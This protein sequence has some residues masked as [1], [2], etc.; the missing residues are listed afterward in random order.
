M[1]RLMI[2]LVLVCSLALPLSPAL[3]VSLSL[4]PSHQ[5]IQL[6]DIAYVDLV[7]SDLGTTI[8]GAFDVDIT[9]D[10]FILDPVVVAF[11]TSLGDIGSGE[12]I[13]GASLISPDTV[14]VFEVSLL[15][16]FELAPLQAVPSFALA[17]LG[18]EGIAFGSSDLDFGDVILSDDFGFEITEVTT[19]GARVDVVPEPTTILLLGVGLAGF[20][21]FR[22]KSRK[23]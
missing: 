12:A 18:F 14:N 17:T 19:I 10:P 5:Q 3:A 15:F 11:G 6:G 2:I 8:L 16:S 20:A 23:A 13:A 1:K 22:G 4:V 9:Y 7:I 21:G